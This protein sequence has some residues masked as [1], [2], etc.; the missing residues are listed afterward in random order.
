MVADALSSLTVR[1][2]M[3][4]ALVFVLVGADLTVESRTAQIHV[5]EA[6]MLNRG[7]MVGRLY[8]EY[9]R[10]GVRSP[11]W[12]SELWQP[13]K[14]PLGNMVIA[15]GLWLGGMVPPELPY[16]YDWRRDY[17]WNVEHR[18]AVRLPP[19]AA[20]RAGRMLVPWFAAAATAA[21][22]LLAAGAGGSAG[23]LIAAVVFAMNPLV[24]LH[25]SLALSDM[26]MMGLALWALLYLVYAVAPVWDGSARRLFRRVFVFGLLVGLAVATKQNGSIVG[27]AG[28]VAFG[29]WGLESMP[30][31]GVRAPLV[32]AALASLVLA[33]GALGLFVLINPGLHRNPIG[34]SAAQVE[35]WDQ[36]FSEHRARRPEQAFT[37]ISERAGAVGQVLMGRSHGALPIPNVTWVL[38]IAGA[39][40]LAITPSNS[41]R[42]RAPPRILLLWSAVTV[43]IITAWVPLDW[44]R[45]FLPVIAVAAVLAGS[46]AGLVRLI[47]TRAS[48]G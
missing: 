2:G 46:A 22:F 21:V 32:R 27:C 23:G 25:G 13:R 29:V 39:I 48:V 24:R 28:I 10:T 47:R 6:W 44:G 1:R 31:L 4:A 40:L 12:D 43:A 20:L 42:W 7:F 18:D 38:T 37:T 41:S 19:E 16:R 26:V 35:A 34:G 30:R 5:D 36:K 17:E 15:A 14:P 45:Y 33:V 9:L 11:E 3:L 8:G